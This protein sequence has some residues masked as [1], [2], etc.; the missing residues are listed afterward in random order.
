MKC[1]ESDKRNAIFKENYSDEEFLKKQIKTNKPLILDIG[2]HIGE[3]VLFFRSIFPNADIFS[4]EPDPDSYI[5]LLKLFPNIDKCINAAVGK[6]T[7]VRTLYQ[8]DIPHLNS[9]HSINKDSNDSLG[10]AQSCSETEVKVN[11]LSLDDLVKKLNISGQSIDLLKIDTQ[12]GEVDV[13][14]GGSDTLNQVQNITLELNLFDFYS[15]KN[16]FLEI[17]SLLPE[18][19]LYSITKLSQNPINYRTDWA[20][21]FYKRIG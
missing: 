1:G 21:V 14:L 6:K 13:L 19:E 10:Y 20:E 9:L 3:S 4:V 17:E 15:R 12:G 7:E 18:F 11:C 16:S 5:R 2:A 8:Y